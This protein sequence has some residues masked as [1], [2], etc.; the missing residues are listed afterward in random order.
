MM[1][2]VHE[3]KD[4]PGV[5]E[6]AWTWLPFFL[7]ANTGLIKKVDLEMSKRFHGV[8]APA[9]EMHNTVLGII[10]EEFKGMPGLDEYLKAVEKVNVT[11]TEEKRA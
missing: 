10:L 1:L 2:L 7:A 8:N 6:V 5:W 9:E 3:R 4:K 11:E